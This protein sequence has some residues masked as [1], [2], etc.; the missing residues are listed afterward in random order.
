MN[1]AERRYVKEGKKQAIEFEK[2]VASNDLAAAQ[3]V[4]G[5]I[6]AGM[7]S[8]GVSDPAEITKMLKGLKI[9]TEIARNKHII[10]G[11]QLKMRAELG[12]LSPEEE[13]AWAAMQAQENNA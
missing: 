8:L 6:V 3:K 12:Q 2:A 1:V 10:L 4:M 9:D 11:T 5:T 13:E 7:L